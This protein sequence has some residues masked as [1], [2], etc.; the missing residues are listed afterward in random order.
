VGHG[1][2]N[3]GGY[4]PRL[5]CRVAEAD[6]AA[7]LPGRFDGEVV[8]LRARHAHDD[9][10]GADSWRIRIYHE[11]PRRADDARREDM[12]DRRGNQRDPA[13]GHRTITATGTEWRT[14]LNG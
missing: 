5:P 10:G 14:G 12:R 8:C 9:A 13:A 6:G 4:A 3:R 11:I 2:R 1:D 7:L